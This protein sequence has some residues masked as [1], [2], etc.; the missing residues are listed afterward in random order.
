[1]DS[2]SSEN[3]GV[4]ARKLALEIM[5]TL[6][7]VKRIAADRL[8]KPAGIP[9]EL[10][11]Q[12]VKGKDATT[13]ESYTKRQAGALILEE[14]ARDGKDGLAIRKLID[15]AAGWDAF[16]LAQNEYMARAVVQKAREQKGV[17]AETDARET[18][19]QERAERERSE[20]QRRERETT[21]QRESALLLE[22]FDHLSVNSEPHERGYLLQD[23]LTRTFVAH[24][25]AVV[26]SFQRN[27]GGEQIDGAFELE[28]WHYIV[29]CR[30][31]EKLANIRELDGLYGQVARSGKQTMGL[32]LSINGWSEHV[33]PIMKQNPDKS[34]ILMEGFDLRMVLAQSIDL[35]RLL[36]G[37]LSALN[38]E[39]EPYFPAREILGKR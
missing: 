27:A 20:R 14:L 3:S 7:N 32:F 13:N 30:W 34:I 36:K 9:D 17:L 22:Q 26:R 33:V 23:L 5:A 8:L 37:K 31:R 29:E 24:G 25:I 6:V 16:D 2:E 10:V 11:R 15:I 18:A 35:R 38:L 1:M 39:S 4:E 21:L 19:D 28:G 12:F